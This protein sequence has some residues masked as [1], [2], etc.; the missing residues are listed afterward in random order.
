MCDRQLWQ[1]D[2]VQVE[3]PEKTWVIV[4][5]EEPMRYMAAMGIAAKALGLELGFVAGGSAHE[6]W[7][8]LFA[9]WDGSPVHRREVA[10][11]GSG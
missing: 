1:K 8:Y 5:P 4:D 2:D 9:I 10:S 6:V 11:L 7:L 3:L